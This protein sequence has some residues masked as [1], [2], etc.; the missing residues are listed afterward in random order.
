MLNTILLT[1]KMIYNYQKQSEPALLL[2]D[3]THDLKV[4]AMVSYN[5]VYVTYLSLFLFI[6]YGMYL[7]FQY[8][9]NNQMPL[10]ISLLYCIFIILTQYIVNSI[11]K[12]QYGY[13]NVLVTMIISI[14]LL[15]IYYKEIIISKLQ[16][17]IDK[18]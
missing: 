15:L 2:I 9:K 8:K 1:T 4:E 10:K 14:L 17:V 13:I 7:Y 5:N 11:Y 12:V 18:H 6:L 3:T 16:S